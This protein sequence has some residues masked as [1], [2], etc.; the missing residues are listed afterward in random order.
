MNNHTGTHLLNFALLQVLDSKEE[1]IDQKG[2]LVAP[3]KLRF[4][5]N[6]KNGLKSEEIERIEEIVNQIIKKDEPVYSGNVGL[7]QA[8][9]VNGLRAVFGEASG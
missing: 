8:K 2:S 6:Y 9:G 5:F 3:E 7:T 1:M 4:D